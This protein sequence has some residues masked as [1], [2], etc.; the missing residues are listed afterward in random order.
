[1]IFLIYIVFINLRKTRRYI[2]IILPIKKFIVLILTIIISSGI[3]IFN[4]N[5]FDN[6]YKNNEQIETFAIVLQNL[7]CDENY[8]TYKISIQ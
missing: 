5:K 4:E 6:I 8:K 7:K 2:N 1:M 3:I